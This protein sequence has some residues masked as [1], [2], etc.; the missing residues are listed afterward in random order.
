MSRLLTGCALV[1][2][3]LGSASAGRTGV[4]VDAAW[5]RTAEGREWAINADVAS[6]CA[7][8]VPCPCVY[9]AA[10]TRGFCEAN[11]LLEIKD[12]HYK[13]IRLDGLSMVM[14][15]RGGKWVKYYVRK[16]ASDKQVAALQKLMPAAAPLFGKVKVLAVEKVPVS[17]ERTATT[18]KFSVPASKVSIALM[19]GQDG[20]PIITQGL[21]HPLQAIDRVQYKAVTLS[22]KGGKQKFDYSDTNGTT[23]RIVAMSDK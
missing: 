3:S 19:K 2:I 5:K 4:V 11:V 22:H 17:V 16:D 10:P 21:K 9:G 7:C 18:V 20:K 14:S 6:A 8:S 12:G 1:L 15:W 13:G 23:A